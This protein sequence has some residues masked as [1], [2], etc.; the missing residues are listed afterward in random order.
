MEF[1]VVEGESFSSSCPTL[2]MPALSIGNVGQLAVDLL[3]SSARARRVAYLDEPSVLPC[4]GNDA[5]GPD[6][7]GDLALAL[8]AYESGPHRL[9]FIQQ[10]SPVIT[11]MMVSFAKNIA[12]FISSIG[13][14]HIVILSSLDS[15]KRR[16]IDASSHMQV[17][18]LSSCNEDGF[19]PEYEKLGW[20][21]LEEYDPSHKRWSFLG[22]LVEGG[23]LSED[24]VDDAD[25]MT[26]NDY[27]ASLPF[28][29]LFT[30]CKAKGLKVSCIMCYC[31]EGDNM[32][33]SFQLAEAVCKLLGHGPEKFHGN[34]S[35]GWTVPLSW[36][37]VYGPPPD[38][39][40]F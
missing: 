10:R 26:I 20:K 2:I 39:S 27:Y 28:A 23:S 9:A 38:M 22:S 19:D 18:Y 7:V 16:V 32:P 34:G 6:A 14:N 12:D 30:A 31:S 37:S 40:I 36:K 13:K 17:Y 29:A 11:G 3:I 1:S 21:K 5:F 24:M 15:G 33:E 35:N 25:E 8:E 4:A